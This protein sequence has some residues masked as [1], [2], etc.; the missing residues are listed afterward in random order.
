MP[1]LRRPQRRFGRRQRFRRSLLQLS[2][3]LMGILR[4]PSRALVCHQGVTRRQHRHVGNVST[5]RGRRNTPVVTF[6][7]GSRKERI[8]TSPDVTNRS[9]ACSQ[10]LGDHAS[11]TPPEA[12]SDDAYFHT[13]PLNLSPIAQLGQVWAYRSLSVGYPL[14]DAQTVQRILFGNFD[15]AEWPILRGI[16]L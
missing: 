2:W 14:L 5:G 4:H 6:R 16:G 11:G 9:A 3:R 1:A 12:I 10:H 7:S 8:G 13:Y 15:H